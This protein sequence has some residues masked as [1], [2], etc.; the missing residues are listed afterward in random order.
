MLSEMTPQRAVETQKATMLN[1]TVLNNPK[2]NERERKKNVW[3]KNNIEPIFLKVN[4]VDQ[5]NVGQIS[6]RANEG[7]KKMTYIKKVN[8]CDDKHKQKKLEFFYLL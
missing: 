6:R 4:D 3:E 8:E 7:D 1:F 2:S 5:E